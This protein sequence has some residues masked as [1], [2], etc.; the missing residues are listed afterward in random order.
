MRDRRN[1]VQGKVSARAAHPDG[2]ARS[3]NARQEGPA[4]PRARARGCAGIG[5][6]GIRQPRPHLSKGTFARADYDGLVALLTGGWIRVAKDRIDPV[7]WAHQFGFERKSES[8]RWRHHFLITARNGQQSSFWFSRED[9][10]E[11]HTSELQSLR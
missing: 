10:S 2:E 6:Q 4:I 11:E 3:G 8:Q 1:Q 9:R 5:R 7:A